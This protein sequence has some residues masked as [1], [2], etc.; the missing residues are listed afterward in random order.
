MTFSDIVDNLENNTEFIT[1]NIDQQEFYNYIDFIKESEK[2]NSIFRSFK[3]TKEEANHIENLEHSK[4]GTKNIN[5]LEPEKINNS[6]QSKKETNNIKVLEQEKIDE[7]NDKFDDY[8]SI[9]GFLNLKNFEKV[10]IISKSDLF[11]VYKIREKKTNEIYSAQISLIQLDKLARDDAIQL[12]KEVNIISQINH[13]SFLKFIGYSPVNF[14]NQRYP[15]IATEF[16]SNR[17]LKDILEMERKGITITGWDETKKLINIYG[18]ASG[19]AYLHSKNILLRNLNKDNIYLDDYLF[20]KIGDFGLSSKGYNIQ[21]ITFHSTSGLKGNSAYLAPELF[22]SNLYTKSSD[23][24]AFS[25][26]VFEILTNEIPFEDLINSNQLFIEIFDKSRRPK[27]KKN[28]PLVYRNLIE[29]CWSQFP[30]ERPS[31]DQ[32]V[33][34]L[35]NEEQFITERIKKQDYL[36]Y[37][38]YID[39]SK[40]IFDKTQKIQ[41][42]ESNENNNINNDFNKPI[43]KFEPNEINRIIDDFIESKNAKELIEFL[44]KNCDFEKTSSVFD[45]CMKSSPD[46]FSDMCKEG[47]SLNNPVAYHKYALNL[48]LN[49]FH[50]KHDFEKAQKLFQKSIEGGF[51]LS[52]FT[53]SRLFY[54]V[55]KDEKQAF[56]TAKKGAEK[57]EKYSKCLFGYFIAHGIGTKKDFKKGVQLILESNATDFYEF[58]STDIG[59]YYA[60]LYKEEKQKSKSKIDD[61]NSYGK[62]AFEFFEKSF[63]RNKTKAAI[64]NYAICFLEGIGVEKN[65]E[66]SKELLKMIPK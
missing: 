51:N 7:L 33:S 1:P 18:I 24:Y 50:D 60:N 62:K 11:K 55:F 29:K 56:E 39:E 36:N 28:I 8:S 59:I 26:I 6:E 17:S 22:G 5:D 65:V 47:I 16:A 32:I 35:R 44:N 46:I 20:P 2:N 14:K 53:L 30:S 21:S 10:S 3:Q 42:N 48:I 52:Y 41:I 19:M 12:S 31:F 27:I 45:K 37:I 38:K 43:Y 9:E 66:K 23:V 4:E 61:E 58:F 63:N 40:I 54:E 64:N 15:V 49:E 34:I 57:D 13:P 25:F